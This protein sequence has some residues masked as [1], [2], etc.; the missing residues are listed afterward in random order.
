M[1][2]LW[3]VIAIGILAAAVRAA[4]ATPIELI[5]NGDFE[6]GT[7]AGWSASS[8]NIDLA[9]EVGWN[10]APSAL[11]GGGISVDDP[12]GGFAAYESFDGSG[13][14]TR[15]L[16][17]SFVVPD[18][19]SHAELSFWDSWYVTTFHGGTL[20]RLFDAYLLDGVDVY[21]LYH[22]ATRNAQPLPFALQSI[23]VTD[24]LQQR[25]G[26]SVR[27]SFVTTIPEY[28]TGP[29]GFGLDNVSLIAHVPEPAPLSLTVL[30]LAIA[31]FACGIRPMSKAA[32][33][34]CLV[35]E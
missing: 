35:I 32:T 5:A 13:P 30:G 16:T 18:T 10:V 29:G 33:R 25:E 6:A 17:Q 22:I 14:K 8:S 15:T 24:F 21:G 1:K 4:T 12:I 23:D 27:L 26:A 11:L 28:G 7:L 9:W 31:G 20:P 3:H 19:I 2:L 34:N